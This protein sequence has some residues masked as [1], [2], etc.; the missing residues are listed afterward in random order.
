MTITTTTHIN[1]VRDALVD[2]RAAKDGALDAYLA[3]TTRTD[4]DAARRVLVVA[5]A[6]ADAAQTAYDVGRRAAL[7][8]L[9]A[10]LFGPAAGTPTGAK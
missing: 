3:A 8:T 7:T 4:Q 9:M 5:C 1:P 2:A 6:T 10:D